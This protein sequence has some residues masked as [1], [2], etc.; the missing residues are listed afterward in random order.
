M[1]V[2]VHCGLVQL[3]RDSGEESGSEEEHGRMLELEVD[4]R[5]GRDEQRRGV[6]HR[7]RTQKPGKHKVC[8]LS[9]RPEYP[10]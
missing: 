1:L 3:P 2:H 7:R 8:L 5:N 4:E 6:N 9:T 10:G